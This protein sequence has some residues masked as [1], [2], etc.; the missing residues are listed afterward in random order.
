MSSVTIPTNVDL[1]ETRQPELYASGITTFV[2]AVLAVC[3]RFWARNLLKT[4]FLLD[5]WLI[6]G[7]L[8]RR[9]ECPVRFLRLR[10]T[11]HRLLLQVS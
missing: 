4:R 8:V 9:F 7:A 6:V 1:S 2:L 3:L 5:D 11:F 10:L